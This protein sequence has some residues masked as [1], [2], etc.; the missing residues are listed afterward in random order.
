[1]CNFYK[2]MHN[3]KRM[4]HIYP[5]CGFLT[6]LKEDTAVNYPILCLKATILVPLSL[7]HTALAFVVSIAMSVPLNSMTE[8]NWA[9]AAI[10]LLTWHS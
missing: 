9:H 2:E 10:A 4:V 7:Y 1:M 3:Q 5:H 6:P 8:S